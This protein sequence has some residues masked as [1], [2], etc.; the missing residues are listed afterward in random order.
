MPA[1]IC[2]AFNGPIAGL[3]FIK[4]AG[5]AD[6]TR[7]TIIALYLTPLIFTGCDPENFLSPQPQS[8]LA[9]TFGIFAI[10]MSIHWLGKPNA[11]LKPESLIRQSSNNQVRIQQ[12]GLTSDFPTQGDYDGDG[13]TDISVWR[14]AASG[15]DSVFY[16]FGSFTNSLIAVGWGINTDFVVNRFDAR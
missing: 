2:D 15:T 9:T 3:F 14:A 6:P 5:V 1:D 16:T 10:T 12:F 11:V 8:N 7:F 4:P 13:R